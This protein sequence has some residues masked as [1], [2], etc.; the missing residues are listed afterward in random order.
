LE[1]KFGYFP[2][3]GEG[4]ELRTERG[5]AEVLLTPGT[6]LRLDE[7]RAIRMVSDK[8]SDT[9]VE[10]LGGSAIL[11]SNGSGAA[12][13]PDTS[14]VL[15]HKQWQ[16]KVG[17]GVYRIDSDPPQIQVYKGQVEVSGEGS[18]A[19]VTARQDQVLPLAA[20]L[21]PEPTPGGPGD[22]FK[23]WAMS[24][25]QAISADNTIAAGI[26]DDPGRY[27][28][29]GLA[30]GGYSYFPITGLS[31]LGLAN[32]YGLSFWSPYQAMWSSIYAPSLLYRFSPGWPAFTPLLPLRPLMPIIP[33]RIGGTLQPGSTLLRGPS[34]PRPLTPARPPSVPVA[35]RGAV[36]LGGHRYLSRGFA[37]GEG[38]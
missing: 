2:S 27:D 38:A 28:G 23:A 26:V 34:T 13:W 14:A 12:F 17:Q 21:V 7:N 36:R 32:P 19:T 1:Q 35:P 4:R 10:L 29:S 24:R 18:P 11:E 37:Y 33:T 15:I 3:V 22:R 9:R 25:S 5:R 30:A 6:L 8:L 20:V 16:M 31:S